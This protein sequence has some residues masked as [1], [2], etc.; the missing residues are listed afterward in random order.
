MELHIIYDQGACGCATPGSR[1]PRRY[2]SRPSGFDPSRKDFMSPSP[3]AVGPGSR[4]RRRR[5]ADPPAAALLTGLGAAL[6]PRAAFGVAMLTRP[7]V[8]SFLRIGWL[9]QRIHFAKGLR[10]S[11][12]QGIQTLRA[13][14]ARL[15]LA[16]VRRAD[17]SALRTR[18]LLALATPGLRS[19]DA[20]AR[21]PAGSAPPRSRSRWRS[22]QPQRRQ[23]ARCVL[24][25]MGGGRYCAI[26]S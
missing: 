7:R 8:P 21:A 15:P 14:S 17:P 4:R 6:G 9:R 22:G 10:P 24:R 1:E 20:T 23:T 2:A 19:P 26:G 12:A 25:M 18:S 13:A 16:R 3:G 11:R 5:Y